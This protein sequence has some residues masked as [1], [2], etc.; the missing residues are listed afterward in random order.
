M[1]FLKIKMAAA[2]CGRA[3]LTLM[4]L[5]LASGTGLAKENSSKKQKLP[6]F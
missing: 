1:Q 6:N 3:F 4:M 2:F 5:S